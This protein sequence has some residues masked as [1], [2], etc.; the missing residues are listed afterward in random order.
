MGLTILFPIFGPLGREL[1]LGETEVG[2]IS[3]AYALMQFLTSSFWGRRSETRGRK[4]V[5]LT[6]V[7]GFG[8]GFLLFGIV[9][10]LGLAGVLSHWPLLFGLVASRAIGGALSSATLP[11]GQAWAADLTSRE[12]RTAG[13]AVVGAAFGLAIIFGPAIG[14]VLAHFFG[15]LA[16]VWVSVGIAALNFALVSLRLP[17]PERR[18]ERKEVAL[19]PVA[20]RV[21]ALLVMAIVMTIAAVSME[22]TIAFYFQDRLGLETGEETAGY[23]GAAL[24]CYG[25][26]AV[27]MQGYVVRRF[28][29]APLNLLRIGLPFTLTGMIVLVFAH[30][31]PMMIV[32]MTLQGIGQGLALPGVTSALSLAVGEGEQGA[33]AG[34]NSSAQGLGRLAGPLIGGTLYEIAAP[35]PYEAA[36]VLLALVLGAVWLSPRVRA[37]AAAR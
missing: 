22:Q 15:L 24:V 5:L 14:A 31:M 10:E 4:P 35:L 23:V 12:D 19:A 28:R 20:R 27:I 6:G 34:L 1:G 11:T 36:S 13:M 3:T 9:A 25:I 7:A 37:L 33:V 26:V 2:A 32:A 17:E 30:D 8:L 21:T 16:P 29:I 18:T